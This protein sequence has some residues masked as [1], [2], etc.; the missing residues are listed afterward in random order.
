MGVRVVLTNKFKIIPAFWKQRSVKDQAQRT[1]GMG[2]I[3]G[4]YMVSKLRIA[5]LGTLPF[6]D[7]AVKVD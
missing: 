2:N 1:I 3:Q 7:A 4:N 5:G 6:A